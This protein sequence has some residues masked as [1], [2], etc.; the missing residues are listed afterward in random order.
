MA[1]IYHRPIAES[2]WDIDGNGVGTVPGGNKVLGDNNDA[3]LK[4]YTENT[5]SVC[6]YG[7]F[8]GS[9]PQG[10]QII[11][12]RVGHR[13]R[14]NGL[15]GLY[16]GWP[17]SYLRINGARQASTKAYKQ[18]GYN[19]SAREVLGAP[20]YKKD[21]VPWTV[22][23]I[24][25]MTSDIGAAVGDIAPNRRNYWC[26]ASEAYI[27]V[28]YDEPLT[29]APSI[30]YP[31]NNETVATSSVSFR[32][33]CPA[34][35]DEQPVRAVFQVARDTAYTQ[36]VRN[37]EGSLN[38]ETAASESK[39]T[40]VAGQPSFTDLGPGRWYVRVKKRDYRGSAY[41][42][43]WSATTS[44]TVTHP[45]LPTPVMTSPLANDVVPSPYG[46]RSA[47]LTT[48]HKG[49]RRVGVGWQFS[50]D[51]N[52]ASGLVSWANTQ[53]AT[54]KVPESGI[55]IW[56]DPQPTGDVEP[57][58]YGRRVSSA[59]PSQYL[60]QGKWYARTRSV[61]TYG[62]T[63]PWSAAVSFNVT[64]RPVVTD[65]TPKNGQAFDQNSGPVRWTFADPWSGDTQTA[66]SIQVIDPA[67]SAV[68]QDT[69]WVNST[70]PRGTISVPNS[71][72][73]K[74][75]RLQI[76]VKDAEG[77]ASTAY[78]TTFKLAL[79]PV[80]TLPYPAP[81]DQ[82]IS[83]Q[84]EITWSSVFSGG[85]AQQ[86]YRVQYLRADT[87]AVVYDSGVVTSSTTRHLPPSAILRNL[88]GYQLVLTVVDTAGLSSEL[89]RTFSTNFELPLGVSGYA[90][91]AYYDDGGYVTVNFPS[92]P[93]DPYFFE[94]RIYRR[95]VG[96]SEWVYAGA[97]QDPNVRVFRDWLV[98][99]TDTW[100]Y[101]VV[102]AATRF[103]SIVESEREPMVP[104][105][106]FSDSYW[107]IVPGEEEKS[108]RL[109]RVTE[110]QY[111][112]EE[113]TNEYVIIGGGR[114]QN[115]GTALGIKGT[116]TAT[117]RHSQNA[118]ATQ[119]L[120]KLRE[121]ARRSQPVLMRDPFGNV[122]QVKI[123]SRSF[124]RMAGVGGAEF[125]D[126]TIPYTEVM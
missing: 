1:R 69:G 117:I 49:E 64:H 34:P 13:Q 124:N 6:A 76:S 97:V 2:D 52:F 40:S 72:Q 126:L 61:D 5:G 31:A 21:F 62:Q 125:G 75:L 65:S 30:N 110:D 73:Q 17:V 29:A 48:Q 101:T 57:D 120:T 95:R 87:G 88:T 8:T 109:R 14:N 56:Y 26:A 77:V 99:G 104:V 43:P 22:A 15:L 63:G 20:L 108:I 107:F 39:Y 80:I 112:D 23:E 82:I 12:V 25:S 54:F 46:V 59:D 92:S 44:F 96:D 7:A 42:S 36:D 55:D 41:E 24:N 68:L 35:Q 78:T 33:N 94:W 66:Y 119:Q 103:G 113:E 91:S 122:T 121:V 98:A 3:T 18:D 10:R 37:Y 28:V 123:G 38:S 53:D 60:A 67:T 50:Q 102:Q 84:P 74:T 79:S 89:R 114:R 11:A 9:I 32:A 105:S 45:A 71:Y 19:D 115:V 93:V 58:K 85:S 100:E 106:I 70:M 90:D 47:K 111:E 118:T 86:A 16:N 81:N 27:V 83:G 116:L 4:R 51:A